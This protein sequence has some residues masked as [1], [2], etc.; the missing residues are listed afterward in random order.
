LVGEGRTPADALLQGMEKEKD[1]ARAMLDRS[2]LT[3]E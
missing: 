2:T 1:P 3:W